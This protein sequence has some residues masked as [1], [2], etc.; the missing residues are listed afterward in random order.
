MVDLKSDWR[1]TNQN[2]YLKNI[3]FMYKKYS[4]PYPEHSHC[5]FCWRK[6]GVGGDIQE[7]Y[8][9]Q[10]EDRWICPECFED[11]KKMLLG[12]CGCKLVSE[13]NN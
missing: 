3:T 5:E 11:F 10:S 8:T 6:F 12:E 1:F 9:N 7:G 4:L 2:Q 13:K